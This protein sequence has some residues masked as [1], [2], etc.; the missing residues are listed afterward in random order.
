MSNQNETI[1]RCINIDW[2]EVYVLE[3]D[4]R[5]PCNADYYRKQGYDVREREYGTR[6]Y[7][8]MFEILDANGDPVIEIRRNPASGSSD[9]NGLCEFSSHIRLPNWMLYQGNPIGFLTDFL[10]KHDYI[11]KRIYRIDIAYDFERFDSGDYPAKFARRYLAGQYRKINQ[12]FLSAHG[13]DT[14]T[15]CKWQS[16]SWG[17]RSSMVTTKLYDKTLEL[18][19]AKND[20]PWIKTCWM[21]NGLID[22][23]MSMTKRDNLGNLYKP[24]IWRIEFA[25]MSQADGWITIEMNNAQKPYKQTIP[26][27]LSMFDSQDKLW[28]RFQDL[29]YNYFHFKV[30]ER[31][32]IRK[33]VSSEALGWVHSHGDEQWQR[34]DRCAD[35]VLFKWDAN[36]QF[37]KLSTAP[38]MRKPDRDE[39]ILKRRLIKYRLLHTDPKIQTACDT[40]IDNISR[41]DALRFVP[42]GDNIDRLAIQR[43]LTAKLNGDER[44]AQTILQE[45]IAILNDKELF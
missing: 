36:H 19:E 12:C 29:A 37:M 16:L 32:K 24:S 18:K 15:E 17:S 13:N 33:G 4:H 9:F 21:V 42:L 5:F 35:K 38:A 2:L 14:W 27:K 20:K 6:V 11:F 39:D 25:M 40:L 31:K 44:S 41:L 28:Q 1:Q 22:N 23:P 34:K 3:S 43:T 26:H 45:M 7:K 8:E 30:N 10:L